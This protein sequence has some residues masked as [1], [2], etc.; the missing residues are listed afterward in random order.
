M[1][2]HF[3]AVKMKHIFNICFTLEPEIPYTEDYLTGLVVDSLTDTHNPIGRGECVIVLSKLNELLGQDV[4]QII[5]VEGDL[6]V[7]K[8]KKLDKAMIQSLL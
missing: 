8:W 3:I 6:K 5:T 1:Q 4:F 7:Y 2:E